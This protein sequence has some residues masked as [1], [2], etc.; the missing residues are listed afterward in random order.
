VEIEV[1]DPVDPLGAF[2]PPTIQLNDEIYQIRDLD[3][4]G[5]HVLLRLDPASVDLTRPEVH[6]RGGPGILHRAWP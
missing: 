5:S 4:G 6:P 3:A 2:L 1:V